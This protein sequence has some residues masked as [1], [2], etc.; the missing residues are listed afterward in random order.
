MT[1]MPRPNMGS[2]VISVTL[3]PHLGDDKYGYPYL[4]RSDRIKF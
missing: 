3:S 1:D 2:K 4:P